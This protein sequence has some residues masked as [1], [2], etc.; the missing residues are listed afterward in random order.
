MSISAGQSAEARPRVRE[1]ALTV[2]FGRYDG[3]PRQQTGAPSLSTTVSERPARS[4][5][6]VIAELN[7]LRPMAEKPYTLAYQVTNG[8]PATNAIYDSYTLPVTDARPIAGGLSLDRQG[9]VLAQKP[10]AVTDYY[11]EAQLETT[12]HDEAAALVAEATGASRVVV[13]DHTVRV[14]RNDIPDRTPG[15]ARLPVMRVHCDYT[16]ASGPQRVR[17]LM[18]EE[19]EALLKKRFAFVN[20]WRPIKGPVIDTPLAVCD[21]TTSSEQDM[22]ASDMVYPDRRGEILVT[23]Y[24]PAHRWYYFPNLRADEALLIK[25]Y[26]SRRDVARFCAHTAFEDPTTP[27]GSPPR[28]SVEIRTVAFFD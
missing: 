2:G 16:E 15:M 26:D 19:A 23:T 28:E 17:D 22:V 1:R 20:V 4:D 8:E 12:C 10:T 14:R 21:V 24:S 27:P 11:D 9:F 13:F 18:G 5:S 7:Y 6:S 3:L 25:C